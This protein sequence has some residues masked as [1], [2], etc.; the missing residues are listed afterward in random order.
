M[1]TEPAYL[2]VSEAARLIGVS[3]SHLYAAMRRG[4]IGG[5]HIIGSRY[6]INRKAFLAWFEGTTPAP[7][8]R[9]LRAVS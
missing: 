8:E 3:R 2:S 1:T 7:A 6:V 9:H 5:A 4:E